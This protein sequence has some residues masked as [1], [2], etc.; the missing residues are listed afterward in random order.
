MKVAKEFVIERLKSPIWGI[1]GKPHCPDNDLIPGGDVSH[2]MTEIRICRSLPDKT[3]LPGEAADGGAWHPDSP[4]NREMLRIILESC[5][6]IYGQG[7]HWVEER[8]AVGV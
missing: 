8:E 5:L 7:T 3:S 2:Q 6:E 1:D 4:N